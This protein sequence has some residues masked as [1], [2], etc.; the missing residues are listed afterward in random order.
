MRKTILTIALLA[1]TIAT[2][3][4]RTAIEKNAA[5]GETTAQKCA[6]AELT[7][8]NGLYKLV[9]QVNGHDQEFIVDTGAATVGLP[10]KIGR[11]MLADGVLSAK[12]SIGCQPTAYADGSVRD[13]PVF[14]VR[15]LTVAGVHIRNVEVTFNQSAPLLGM[16]ALASLGTVEFEEG[17][18]WLHEH[19]AGD[20][21]KCLSREK[22][23]KKKGVL[24]LLHDWWSKDSLQHGVTAKSFPLKY[25][26]NVWQVEAQVNG[27]K[28]DFILDSGASRVNV[29]AQVG[30][31]LLEYDYLSEAD[32]TG[33][34]STTAGGGRQATGKRYNVKSL[35]LGGDAAEAGISGNAG[36]AG[37]SGGVTL[38]DVEMN[39]SP[40]RNAENVLGMSALRKMQPF[41]I[42]YE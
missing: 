15:D 16:L 32:C 38:H 30:R 10:E 37:M 11:Q 42:S 31:Y 1:C 26:R 34:F 40:M 9:A 14:L 21:V 7:T 23:E 4:A 8:W 33:R 22:F 27:C 25:Y 39:I 29:N 6:S 5:S 41:I 20:R 35:T 13:V 12:D 36:N 17:R 19:K 24:T 3:D 2:A 18:L 28:L